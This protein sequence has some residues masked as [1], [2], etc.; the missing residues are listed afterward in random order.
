MISIDN[1]T[2]VDYSNILVK[3]SDAFTTT[4]LM[5]SN[6]LGFRNRLSYT[7]WVSLPKDSKVPAL[8]VGFYDE[9][10]LA[11]FKRHRNYSDDT[12][13]VETVIQYLTKNV[14][15]IEA[16]SSRYNPKY[17]YRVAYNCIGS[18]W[19]E[20]SAAHRAYHHSIDHYV[21]GNDDELISRLDFIPDN[22]NVEIIVELDE[23]LSREAF[24]RIVDSLD[25]HTRTFIQN[26]LIG[27]PCRMSQE[28]R[29]ET[30]LKLRPLFEKFKD[31]E[32]FR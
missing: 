5:F 24:W 28:K 9:I 19:C 20:G 13:S 26:I 18:L 27:T 32:I 15:M 21:A 29:T 31:V 8:F 10:K 3:D 16:D 4:C 2:R 25:L 7:D 14:P 11:N 6:Y 1:N 17:I 22:A 23:E 30:L 12:L